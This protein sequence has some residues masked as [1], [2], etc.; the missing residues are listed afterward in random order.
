M[1]NNRKLFLPENNYSFF[2]NKFI[3]YDPQDFTLFTFLKG[4]ITYL[5]ATDFT[6]WGLHAIQHFP[7]MYKYHKQHHDWVA[8]VAIAGMEGDMPD[9]FATTI[10]PGMVGHFF[11]RHI[12]TS[13]IMMAI[14]MWSILNSHSGYDLG[15][16]SSVAHD[17][18]HKYGKGNYGFFFDSIFNTTLDLDENEVLIKGG[19]QPKTPIL[20]KSLIILTIFLVMLCF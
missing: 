3:S 1:I 19:K 20:K 4:L 7:K 18:H 13:Y 8:S 15:H 6:L 16:I 2:L 10:F 14:V 17:A 11:S 9:F 12:Y 5:L